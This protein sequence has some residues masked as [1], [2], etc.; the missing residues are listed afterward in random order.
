[1]CVAPEAFGILYLELENNVAGRG[2]LC[3]Y[4]ARAERWE[5]MADT[6]EP[7]VARRYLSKFE[8]IWTACEPQAE[9]RPQQL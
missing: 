5:G 8:S 7:A 2:A 6:S 3:L 1:M 4:R 9:A